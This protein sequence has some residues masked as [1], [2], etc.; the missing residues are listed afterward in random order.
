MIAAVLLRLSAL[1]PSAAR[2]W[3]LQAAALCWIAALAL[4]LWRFTPMLIRPRPN[5]PPSIGSH[6]KQVKISLKP[7]TP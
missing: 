3:L 7:K 1:W 4:Y 6:E 5:S 2:L